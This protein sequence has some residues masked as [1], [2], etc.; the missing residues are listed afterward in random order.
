MILDHKN[1]MIE[2]LLQSY[3]SNKSANE[4]DLS[5]NLIPKEKLKN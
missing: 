3:I 4:T 1:E 5:K 2:M